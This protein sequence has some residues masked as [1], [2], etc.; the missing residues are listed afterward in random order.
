MCLVQ[1][2]PS[3]GLCPQACFFP[4]SPLMPGAYISGIHKLLA[5]LAIDKLHFAT[6]GRGA[7][8][9]LLCC[10]GIVKNNSK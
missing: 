1:F 3:Q 8:S 7:A 5:F 9:Q 10:S 2:N 4:G 6:C